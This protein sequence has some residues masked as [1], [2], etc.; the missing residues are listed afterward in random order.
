MLSEIKT[1]LENCL[2]KE[3]VSDEPVDRIPYSRDLFTDSLKVYPE[4]RPDMVVMPGSTLDVQNVIRVANQYKFPVNIIGGG[5][6]VLAGSIPATG[7]I[8]IDLKRMKGIHIDRD[9]LTATVESGVF[10]TTLTGH[11]KDTVENEDFPW[12]PYFTGAPG[13]SLNNAT[14][15]FQGIN[16]FAG[17]KYGVGLQNI[18]SLE[19]VLPDG[20]VI[21]TSSGANI[22]GVN[23]WMQGP[24]PTLT[25]LPFFALGS[26]GVCTKITWSLHPY[27]QTYKSIWAYFEDFNIPTQC[28]MELLHKEIGRGLFIMPAWTQ[29][30]YSAE[31]REEGIR[32][33][34]ASPKYMLGMG[35]EGTSRAVEYQNELA[36]EIIDKYGGRVAPPEIVEVYR[37]HEQNIKGWG[38]SNSPR[39]MRHLGIIM[40]NM[41]YL[42]VDQVPEYVER[43][44]AGTVKVSEFMD[45][46]EPGFG[47]IGSGAQLY[48]YQWGHYVIAEYIFAY[49]HTSP[50]QIKGVWEVLQNTVPVP[51]LMGGG[52]WTVGREPFTP[53]ITGSFYDAAKKF[54][55]AVDKNNIMNPNIG[56]VES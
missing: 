14:N 38:Q 34:K 32:L 45:Y 7:G 11:F 50:E 17:L 1:K 37:G 27:P 44:E 22:F 42:S 47:E 43:C 33:A 39:L 15:I 54:K 23:H 21:N 31:T 19:M 48:T 12:R 28:L 3:W 30:A 6:A 10:V 55:M 24:G 18:L 5:A 36:L 20:S 8:M 49:D 51:W 56:I 41:G 16:K 46:P 35:V 29:G 53:N 13:P 52:L 25:Y 4:R 2:G 26:L 40:S 9:N